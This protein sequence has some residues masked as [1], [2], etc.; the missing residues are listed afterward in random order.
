MFMLHIVVQEQRHL[1][2]PL[3]FI[4]LRSGKVDN[5]RIA[6]LAVKMFLYEYLTY[7]SNKNDDT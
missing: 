4:S 1:Y 5:P 3:A 2:D 6:Y 7:D